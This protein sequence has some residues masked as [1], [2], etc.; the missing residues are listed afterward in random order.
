MGLLPGAQQHVGFEDTL[1]H[2]ER[3]VL[4]NLDY[5]IGNCQLNLGS[6]A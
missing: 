6:Y 1:E 3:D 2:Q 5:F 4:A